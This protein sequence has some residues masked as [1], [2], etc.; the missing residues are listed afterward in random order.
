MIKKDIKKIALES[1]Y[2]NIIDNTYVLH[3]TG[4]YHYF[5]LCSPTKKIKNIYRQNIWPWIET[6][7]N[8]KNIPDKIRYPRPSQRDSYPKL[9][10]RVKKGK[11][12]KI[13]TFPCKTF[14]IH[15]IVAKAFILN[16]KN[17]P[18][19]DHKN[20]IPSDYRIPNLRWVTYSENNK[21]KRPSIGPDKMYDVSS[22]RDSV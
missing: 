2:E 4:G 11:A 6:L 21:G 8:K 9:N 15:L 17:K 13:N 12:Y 1:I 7:S 20:S 3:S 14:Y 18:I 22:Y 5:S 19:V 16:N 10:L